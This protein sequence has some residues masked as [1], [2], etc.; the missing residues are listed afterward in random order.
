[1]PTPQEATNG[2]VALVAGASRGLGLLVARELGRRGYRVVICA[3]EA[4]EL[5]EARAKLHAEGLMVESMVCDVADNGEVTSMVS[6]IEATLGPIEVL[7]TVAGVI[8]VGPLQSLEREHFEQAVNIMLWGP[9]NLALAVVDSMR[10]R[11]RGHIATVSSI[12][13]MISVPH[14]LPYGTAKFGAVGFSQGLRAEMSG[15][16]VKVTTVVPG[17]MRTGSHLRAEFT[18]NQP[19]EYGWFSVGASFPLVSIDA[20]RA[21]RQIVRRVLDGKALV[22]LTPLAKLAIRVHGLAPATTANLLGVLGRMLPGAPGSEQGTVTG[23]EARDRL[24][25]PAQKVL[26]AMTVLGRRAAGRF[27]E[28]G[29]KDG[30]APMPGD[31]GA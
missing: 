12:G 24:P 26:D 2:Q 3:R 1:M 19:A 28:V 25:G 21:A 14:L 22:V 8:Q 20:E 18:G 10:G 29:E 27:N 17:L 16:G 7:V 4:E 15:T 5:D 11:G 13:G 9:V 31:G 6:R 23:H 30:A